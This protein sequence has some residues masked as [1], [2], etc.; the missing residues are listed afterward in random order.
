M[1][2]TYDHKVFKSL[3]G[4]ANIQNIIF[5]VK[6]IVVLPGLSWTLFLRELRL[7][8]DWKAKLWLKASESRYQQLGIKVPRGKARFP[9]GGY[10]PSG[11]VL[12]MDFP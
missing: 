5:L 9:E 11:G 1:I 8:S 6:L 3:K 7:C 2:Y 4:F 10:P 12:R